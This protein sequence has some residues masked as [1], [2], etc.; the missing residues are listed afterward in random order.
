MKQVIGHIAVCIVFMLYGASAFSQHHS[1]DLAFIPNQGQWD[2]L[3]SYRADL[4]GGIF[5][6]EENGWT[7]WVAGEGYDDLWNVI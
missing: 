3:I 6:M 5:W 7:A 4:D 2:S 1:S